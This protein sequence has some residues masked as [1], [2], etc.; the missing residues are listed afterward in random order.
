MPH[1]YP[2]DSL[3]STSMQRTTNDQ[4]QVAPPGFHYMPDGTLMSD[5]EHARLYGSEKIIMGIDLDLSDIPAV[6]ASRNFTINGSNGSIFSLEIKNEDSYYYNFETKAFQAAKSRLEKKQL[7]NNQ[8][9]GTIKFPLVTD[10]DQYDVYLWAEP[11]T[12]HSSYIE[13]RFAD[14]SIDI[15]SSTGSSSLLLQ[16]VI[17]Q[18]TDLTLTITPFSP[19]SV[20]DIIKSSSR[21]D[22]TITISRGQSR[23]KIPFS[24]SCEVNAATKSY[25]VLKQPFASDFMT[26]VSPT[27]GSA[28][29]DL[30][31]EDIYPTVNSKLLL[32]INLSW[33]LMLLIKWLLVIK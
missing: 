18:Y 4:G 14:G 32:E 19:N 25:K 33:I 8:Y 12:S 15:N 6:G 5:A 10:D 28:P 22:D 31:G 26:F 24:I 11:G 3:G 23:G 1:G 9:S 13:S 7:V 17:Y 21:V 30:P 29:E 27:I 16:K 2:H 20:T